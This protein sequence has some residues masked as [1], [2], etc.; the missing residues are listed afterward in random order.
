MAISLKM[1]Q[2]GLKLSSLKRVKRVLVWIARSFSN[3]WP[4]DPQYRERV[5]WAA[6]VTGKRLI[7]D[8]PCLVQALAV[9][10]LFTR[11]NI[12]ADLCLGVAKEKDGQLAAHA[13]VESEGEIVIGG[14]AEDLSRYTRLPDLD[15][16]WG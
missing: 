16:K 2:L 12:P 6:S 1:I 11:R 4:V 5:A 3:P 7:G 13:W 8:Q 9:Q 10:L 15:W 14:S